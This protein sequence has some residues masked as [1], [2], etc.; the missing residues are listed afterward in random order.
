MKFNF[1]ASYVAIWILVLF[2]G[3]LVLALLRKLEELRRFAERVDSKPKDRLPLGSPAPE[4]SGF[5]VRSGKQVGTHSLNGLG[6]LILFLTSG[7]T[8]CTRLADSLSQ[9]SV[10]DLPPI[11]ALCQGG[12]QG[13]AYFVS[14]LSSGIYLLLEGAGETATRYGV[15]SSPTAIVIDGE[16]KI[17]GY[18]NPE[19]IENLKQLVARS[20][21]VDL[22]NSDVAEKPQM[23]I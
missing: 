11:I 23:A 19:N 20:L 14:K 3:L 17:R 16:Q 15:S 7:C 13:C 1:V 12:E 8:A 21:E 9:P 4:F 18:G 6:G 5:D 2:Q 22:N 10:S